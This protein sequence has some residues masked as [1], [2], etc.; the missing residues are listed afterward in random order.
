M[1]QRKSHRRKARATLAWTIVAFIG[2]QLGFNIVLEKWKPELSDPE[3]ELRLTHFRKQKAL[4]PDR[5]ALLVMG[6]SRLVTGF[7]PE[8]LPPLSKASGKSPLVFNFSHFGAGPRL[9]LVQMHRLIRHRIRPKWVVLEV[10]PPFLSNEGHSILTTITEVRD[11]PVLHPYIRRPVLYGRFLRSRMVPFYQR[12]LE[13]CRDFLPD[14]VPADLSAAFGEFHFEGLGGY[15]AD[16][17]DDE[18][19]AEE[20]ARRTLAARQTYFAPLQRFRIE[21]SA[22]RALRQTIELGQRHG[23]RFVLLLAPEGS[24][25]RSWYA[26]SVSEQ[27]GTYCRKLGADYGI[28]VI[29]A[30]HWLADE[31][32]FD[33]HHLLRGG[34]ERF[35][36]RLAQEVL[37]PLVDGKLGERGKAGN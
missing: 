14:F 23:I 1:T 16:F 2:L 17:L 6:S 13:L 28:P 22:D 36:H 30:R 31:D 21:R 18:L 20:L 35:T 8:L 26:P 11:L 37:Q 12:R 27:I 10:M 9:N 24:S 5:P 25:F 32:F 33:G 3:F 4:E 29:D 19:S 15:N 7:Q 34:A